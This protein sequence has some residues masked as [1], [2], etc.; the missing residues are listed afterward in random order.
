MSTLL[1]HTAALETKEL[2]AVV[3]PVYSAEARGRADA[4]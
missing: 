4:V 3:K 1:A 2:D